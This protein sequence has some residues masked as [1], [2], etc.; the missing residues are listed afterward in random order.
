MRIK[1]VRD[2]AA[3]IKRLKSEGGDVSIATEINASSTNDDAAGAKAVY[4]FVNSG[5]QDNMWQLNTDFVGSFPIEVTIVDEEDLA[6]L[7][8]MK[9][10][11][12]ADGTLPPLLL[13]MG[14]FN[15]ENK[16][17]Y[18][19]TLNFIDATPGYITFSYGRVMDD[20]GAVNVETIQFLKEENTWGALYSC[21]NER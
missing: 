10:A 7:E 1:E 11:F 3:M 13:K 21:M 6:N 18:I 16:I 17:F 19:F 4:D 12:E 15:D 5:K 20:P 9:A 14:V 8:A 2:V